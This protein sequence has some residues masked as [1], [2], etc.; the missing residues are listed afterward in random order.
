[1]TRRRLN[2]GALTLAVSFTLAAAGAARADDWPQWLG[3]QRDGVWREQGLVAKFADE[4]PM[5]R[6][7]TPIAEGYSGPAVAGGRVVITDRVLPDGVSNPADSFSRQRVQGRER[8]LCLDEATGKV[9][10]KYDYDCPYT[11]SY[12]AGPRATPVIAGG[13]VYTLG[14][15]GHLHCFDIDS[16]A[17]VWSKELPKEYSFDVPLWGCCGH[18]LVDG[19]RLICL[20]GGRGSVVVAFNKDTG[21]EIWKALSAR[22]PG[23]APP[24]I[25]T[26]GGMRQLIVWHPESVNSL[27][28]ETGQVYWT[29]AYG[30]KKSLKAGLAIPTPRL[31][32][33]HLFLTVFYDGPLMLK[34]NGTKKPAIAWKGQGR[35]ELPDDTD[36]LHSIM[37][38]PFIKDGH[39]YGVC[40]HG[41]LRCLDAGTGKRLWSTHKATTGKSVRWGNAFLVPIQDT[42]RYVLFNERGDLILAELT[43]K[44]YQEISRAQILEPTN[45]M[46]RG[47]KVVWSHPAFANRSVYVR[48]D[49]EIICVSLASP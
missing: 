39:I 33:G 34:L 3:P 4:G 5:V 30:A 20:A 41:E 31:A 37:S 35:G 49:R 25:Y 2:L 21:K 29:Q 16:G 36:G 10:W 28:P 11:V 44:G 12:A 9:L 32:D 48:N 47:R 1:M 18:P 13:K 45:T 23:Y 40:S 6:W 38:T 14:A 42:D 43:P 22:E 24:M 26:I 8:V 27:N 15:M 46:A 7:R 19:N 17:I